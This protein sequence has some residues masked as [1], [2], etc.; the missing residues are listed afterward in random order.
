MRAFILSAPVGLF[1]LGAFAGPGA[2]DADAQVL[3]WRRVRTAYTTPVFTY[4]SYSSYYY[5]STGYVTSY[6]APEPVT[7]YSSPVYYTSYWPTSYVP[8]PVV[9]APAVAVSAY[10]VPTS[11]VPISY[12]PVTTIDNPPGYSIYYY[13]SSFTSPATSYYTTPVYYYR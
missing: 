13:G 3:R 6:Y 7:T 9:A 11:S 4:P 5:G 1:G 12:Y 8:A 10:T 2:S